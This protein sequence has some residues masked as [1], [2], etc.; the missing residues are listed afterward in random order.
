MRVLPAF[1]IIRLI[2]LK[3]QGIFSLIIGYEL[4][5]YFPILSRK[6]AS[7]FAIVFQQTKEAQN[8]ELFCKVLCHNLCCVVHAIYELGVEPEFYKE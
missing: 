3:F 1:V 7:N 6:S 8:N 2:C 5:R 4:K